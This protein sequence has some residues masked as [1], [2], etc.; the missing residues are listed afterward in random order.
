MDY[1]PSFKEWL[2]AKKYSESTVRNSLV[3]ISKYLNFCQT[4]SPF[5]P[6]VILSSFSLS[7]Y[8]SL[9]STQNNTSRYLA[10]LAKFCQFALDQNLITTNPLD[11]IL[12]EVK[13]DSAVRKPNLDQILDSF[14]SYLIKHHKT[15]NTITN[16]INDLKQYINFCHQIES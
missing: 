2:V 5:S 16:Y 7:S 9:I 3:D 6:P 8:I 13:S 4:Q 10:S 15:D 11:K 14:K 12:S 1:L